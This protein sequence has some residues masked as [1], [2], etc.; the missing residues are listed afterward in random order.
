MQFSNNTFRFGYYYIIIWNYI[1]SHLNVPQTSNCRNLPIKILHSFTVEIALHN[2]SL[3][4]KLLPLK[5]GSEMA[6]GG[7]VKPLWADK[8]HTA[9]QWGGK[10]EVRKLMDW[11]RKNHMSKE[12]K[13]FIHSPLPMGRQGFSHLQESW[14]PSMQWWLGET[15]TIT[16]IAPLPSWLPGFYF[17]ARSLY[18]LGYPC[19]WLGLAVSAVSPPTFFFNASPKGNGARGRGCP[20][21][22]SSAQQLN[23]WNNPVLSTLIS[24]RKPQQLTAAKKK[25]NQNN[26]KI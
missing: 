11:V 2:D 7:V 12:N 14:A 8:H 19:G 25:V 21:T 20:D 3:S 13:E 6:S 4:V 17:W 22:A 23:S 5:G 18:G 1:N 26:E 24:T 16:L 9:P 10:I 15:N